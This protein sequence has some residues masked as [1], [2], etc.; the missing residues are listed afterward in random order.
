MQSFTKAVRE[1]AGGSSSASITIPASTSREI[2]II[3]GQGWT[4]PPGLLSTLFLMPGPGRIS[5]L[6]VSMNA[7]GGGSTA[8]TWEVY[9]N[10]SAT[11]LSINFT[12]SDT[13]GSNL[14]NSVT[15]VAGDFLTLRGTNTG[16]GTTA[17]FSVGFSFLNEH[18]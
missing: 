13:S 3:G 7:S 11:G 1:Y 10:G 16:T 6:R 15:Y 18:F 17:S 8:I 14:T 4:T 12:S 5:K 9:K 2:S